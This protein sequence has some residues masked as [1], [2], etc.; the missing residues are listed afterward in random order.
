MSKLEKALALTLAVIVV[1]IVAGTA[2][3]GLTGSWAKKQARLAVP[4]ALADSGVYDG[5]GRI[6]AKTSDEKATIV[7]VDLAF[8]YDSS[9]R[10]FREELQRKRRDLRAAADGFFSSRRAD[11]LRPA[12]EATVKAALRDTLNGLLALGAIEELYFSEFRVID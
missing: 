12:N 1:V 6:R 2:W 5:L 9:D 4:T 10:Q 3:G 11:E 7:V 8:P